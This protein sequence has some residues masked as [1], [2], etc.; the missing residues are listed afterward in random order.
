VGC[1]RNSSPA[2]ERSGEAA[3]I[4]ETQFFGDIVR[5]MVLSE[6]QLCGAFTDMLTQRTK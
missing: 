1:G 6:E 3:Q 2:L 4:R 5:V